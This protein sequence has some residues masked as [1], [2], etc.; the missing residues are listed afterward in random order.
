MD[1]D[2]FSHVDGSK[3]LKLYLSNKKLLEQPPQIKRMEF[4]KRLKCPIKDKGY[5]LSE[6]IGHATEWT[7]EIMEPLRLTWTERQLYRLSFDQDGFEM[8]Y[9]PWCG[10]G[11]RMLPYRKLVF[12]CQLNRLIDNS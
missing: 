9:E 1:H 12:M 3:Q 11:A 5:V 4:G 2:F 6:G 10:S 7:G 8:I